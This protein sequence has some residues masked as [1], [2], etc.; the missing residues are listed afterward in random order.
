MELKPC[1][2]CGG[3]A[4]IF[5]KTSIARGATRGWE[6]GIRCSKCGVTTP[7]TDYCLEIQLGKLG[8]ITELMDER[9]MAIDAWN[10]RAE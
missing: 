9:S 5:C 7:K 1:P 6:F 8:A 4:E 3:S 10:R 2:F